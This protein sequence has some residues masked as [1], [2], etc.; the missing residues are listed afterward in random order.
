MVIEMDKRNN[1]VVLSL[2]GNVGDVKQVFIES[3]NL[4]KEKVGKVVLFSPLYQ[5]KAWG[6]EN[7]PDF[8]NQVI[9]IE[10]ELN[11]ENVLKVCM[12]IESKLGRVRTQKW[13][14]RIIDIDILFYNDEVIDS[15]DLTIPHPYVHKRNFVLFP[16]VDVIPTFKHPL[17]EKSMEELKSE[18]EDKLEVV[19]FSD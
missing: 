5:T 9:V 17:L 14:Q 8:L 3:I 6:V 2:G 13:Y 16:L 10:S 19:N 18:C 7:Q 4:L 12:T 15:K 11:P 1:I